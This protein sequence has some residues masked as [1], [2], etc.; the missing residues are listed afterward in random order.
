MVL[1]RRVLR[2]KA[3]GAFF[4]KAGAALRRAAPDRLRENRML[5]GVLVARQRGRESPDDRPPFL[6]TSGLLPRFIE[7]IALH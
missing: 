6:G 1:N 2:R 5:Q 3:A 7:A 4:G